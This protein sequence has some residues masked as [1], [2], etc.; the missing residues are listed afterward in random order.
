MSRSPTTRRML[1]VA[2]IAAVAAVACS[3]SPVPRPSPPSPRTGVVTI[4]VVGTNDV[5]GQLGRLP[6]LGGYVDIL[7]ELRAA[8]G[9]GVVLVDGGDMFQGTIESNL[10]EGAAM[11]EAY[12]ALGYAAAA[13][14]NHEFDFGPVGEA[15]TPQR[16][17]DDPRGALRA[18]A[19]QA[20]TA[21]FALLAANLIDERTGKRVEWPGAS[22]TKLHEV[23]GVWVGI[24]GVTTTETPYTTIAT[25]F[26]GL[27]VAPLAPTIVSE[28][29]ALRERGADVVIVVAHAGGKCREFS[30]PDDLSSCA[31]DTEI[32]EVARA[33]PAGA[34]DVIVAGHSHAGV[35]HRVNGIPIIE[36]FSKA[37]AFGRVDL[38]VDRRAGRVVSSE[39]FS[40]QSLC[41]DA[42][43]GAVCAPGEYEG[44]TVVEDAR[45][46]QLIAVPVEAARSA[47]ERGVGVTVE[48]AV[49]AAYGR[50]SALGNLF[51]DMMRVARPDADVALTNGGGLRAD[52]PVGPLTYGE[53]YEA[54]PFDNRFALVQMRGADLRRIVASNLRGSHGIFS[55]SGVRVVATCRGSSLAVEL[56]R[57]DGTRITDEE[58]L[59]IAT[60]DFLAAGGDGVFGRLK[61][62]KG[63][64][65][66]DD[67][68]PI[69]DAIAAA[70]PARGVSLS[71]E[72][73]R[74]QDRK[75]PRI[76]YPGSRPVL[77]DGAH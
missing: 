25:N 77:C 56:A 62:P 10:N 12:A 46:A 68:P 39:I 57:E 53:L 47:R 67:G 28:A 5:H 11:V 6:L 34:V 30:D 69:R 32:F 44:H 33:L 26:E 64:I 38:A 16:A 9:G 42:S 24:I 48:V 18:R 31:G 51:A 58:A 23:A 7:R 59:V 61:L 1:H 14:G 73:P 60:S 40:P 27:S 22:A 54:M 15:A 17:D 71:G 19:A 20:V 74:L 66:L 36:S 65:R 75:T 8:D 2:L 3:A 37:R 45:V 41:G 63:A 13:I 4:T 70:L 55:L 76:Q 50:E 29:A 72:D 43:R 35:A 21:G 52:L 49:K